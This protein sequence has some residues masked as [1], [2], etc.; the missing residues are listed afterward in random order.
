MLQ[1]VVS[2]GHVDRQDLGLAPLIEAG[3]ARILT[4]ETGIPADRDHHPASDQYC[5]ICASIALIGTGAPSL[6]P[7]LIVPDSVLR[8]SPS[9]KPTHRPR[10]QFALSFQARGPPIA[11]FYHRSPVAV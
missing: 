4:D 2:F 11:Q 7:V 1:V 5:P 9:E 8:F 3:Q 10:P 6:S